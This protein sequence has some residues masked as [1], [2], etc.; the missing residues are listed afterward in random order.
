VGLVAHHA[1]QLA[2]TDY[3]DARGDVVLGPV[4]HDQQA[5]GGHV[6]DGPPT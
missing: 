3:P 6:G 1:R 4:G 5:I 2:G